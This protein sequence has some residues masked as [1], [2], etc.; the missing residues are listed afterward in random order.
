MPRSRYGSSGRPS[1]MRGDTGA[2][3]L[4]TLETPL[5]RA[6]PS[7]LNSTT[8]T[9]T[10]TTHETTRERRRIISKHRRR[11]R[12]LLR[13]WRTLSFKHTWVNPLVLVLLIVSAYLYNPTSSSPFHA[14]I[15]LSYPLSNKD[16]ENQRYG[17]GPRDFAFV[18][19]YV[20]VLSFAREFLMQMLLRPLAIRRNIQSRAKQSRFMEQMYTAI[21][22]AIFGPLGLYIM[23]QTPIWYFRT[24]AFF[25]D[26]PHRDHDGLFKTYYLLQ[27]SY[28]AQQAIV[29]LLQLEKPRKD[30]KELV[31]HHIITLAL[32]GLSY[33]FHFTHMGLAV[34]I[35]HDISDFFLATSKSLSY[36]S[37]PIVGPYFALFVL[38][39]IYMRHYLNLHILWSTLTEFR[40]IG[41]YELD[42]DAQQYKCP[43]S[44]VI[45]FSLLASL[46]AINLFWL[47]LILRIAKNYVFASHVPE[48]DRSDVEDDDEQEKRN[49]AA[50]DAGGGGGGGGFAPRVDGEMS[51]NGKLK[52]A[53]AGAGQREVKKEK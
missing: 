23:R 8:T 31:G 10:T 44:Q 9:T 46:Q 43:L 35:T 20:L 28:W 49:V 24:A 42:W 11:T 33:R 19:F 26:F 53:G 48:D 30:F 50:A 4:S 34:Y 13:R 21:Y 16:P 14:A 36:V 51:P 5:S 2:P 6:S 47:F 27:A 17:K 45:T 38:I 41:P 32:I 37:S 40:T 15:F 29:L 1:D 3:A 52:P 12:T 25:E 7:K 39:W 18:G 22:F